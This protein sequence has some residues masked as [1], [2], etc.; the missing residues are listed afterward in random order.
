MKKFLIYVLLSS[1]LFSGTLDNVIKEKVLKCG[2]NKGLF[3]FSK[4]IN[5]RW[6]G[7]DVDYCRA[8][9]AVVLGDSN[10]VQFIPLTAQ[11][12]FNSLTNE[13]IDILSRNT[14]WTYKRDASLGIN[15]VGVLYYDGQGFMVSKESNITETKQLDNT[16][17]CFEKG[18]TIE[19]NLRNYFK[20]YKFNFTPKA[21]ETN[22]KAIEAFFSSNCDVFTSDKSGLYSA[23]AQLKNPDNYIIL[24]D[25]ISK[26]PLSPAVKEGDDEWFDIAKWTLNTLLEAEE[27]GITS[28]NINKK[29]AQINKKKEP[30]YRAI[31][32]VGNYQE[33]F[34]KNI[35][36]SSLLN[37]E[38]GINN[39]WIN[40]G[41][42]Y[43]L[44]F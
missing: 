22:E 30:F 26:E 18:T 25:I 11:D 33:I 9:A 8:L 32:Q 27:I 20:K 29:M 4:I 34:D 36:K 23:K 7:I 42:L 21:Y 17:I 6:E 19:K 2:V 43:P 28:K 38:R 39:L 40:G 16:K 41:L 35:G 44:P 14:T 37:I 10:K 1:F 5:N 24:S 15:F 13:K 3:G 31:K 12:R